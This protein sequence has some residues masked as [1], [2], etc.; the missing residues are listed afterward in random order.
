MD[1]VTTMECVGCGINDKT[2]KEIASKIYDDLF[3]AEFVAK[4]EKDI[5]MGQ[6]ATKVHR[7]MM[8]DRI[9]QIISEGLF[10]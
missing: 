10:R 9:A 4:A 5:E 7:F 3:S 8:I 6:L 1:L 2:P